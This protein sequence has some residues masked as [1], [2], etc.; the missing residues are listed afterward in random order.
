MNVSV[1]DVQ[2]LHDLITSVG[3]CRHFQEWKEYAQG[4][5]FVCLFVFVCC[6]GMTLKLCHQET[7]SGTALQSKS[8]IDW[9]RT[10]GGS[11]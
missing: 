1:N 8:G 11:E 5:G 3:M 10:L 7:V 9:G 4:F 2:C 6:W